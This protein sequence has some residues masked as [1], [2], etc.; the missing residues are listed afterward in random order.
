MHSAGATDPGAG[1]SSTVTISGI[2]SCL[3]KKE[4]PKDEGT[5][6]N[7]VWVTSGGTRSDHQAVREVQNTNRYTVQ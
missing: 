1:N 4:C 2:G 5:G 3:S 7:V 6:R